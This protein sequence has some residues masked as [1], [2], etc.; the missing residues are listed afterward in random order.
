MT[1]I[2]KTWVHNRPG[3][4]DRITGLIRRKGWNIRTLVAGGVDEGLSQIDIVLE[5]RGLDVEAL[6]EYLVEMDAI[7]SFE[8]CTEQ[9]HLVREILI[10][11]LHTDKRELVGFGGEAVLHAVEQA[12]LITEQGGLCF[13][14][15]S[16]SAAEVDKLL[17]TLCR[18][19]IRCVYSGAL[20]LAYSEGG[21]TFASNG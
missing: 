18:L 2:I 17:N 5:G 15:Y 12:R 4:L 16:D 14:E 8:K 3:V 21:D 9:S 20:T 10:F 6:G 7:C 1:A 11:C 19:N 13:Y